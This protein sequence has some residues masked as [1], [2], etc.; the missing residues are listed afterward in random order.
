MRTHAFR[1]LAAAALAVAGCARRP[2]WCAIRGAGGARPR[3]P[4]DA[5][6]RAALRSATPRRTTSPRPVVSHR[7]GLAATRRGRCVW[8]PNAN[9]RHR[10]S[11]SKSSMPIARSVQQR[12]WNLIRDE[13]YVS[14][15]Q[16]TPV[17]T[18]GTAVDVTLVDRHGRELPMPTSFDD[19][20]SARTAAPRAF[21]R[22]RAECA[23]ARTR[24]DTA[25]VPRISIRVVALRSSRLGKTSAARRR[26]DEP[27]LI[28]RAAQIGRS[29][30][31]C[32][33]LPLLTLF[34]G[35]WGVPCELTPR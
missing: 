23:D 27:A 31:H 1:L 32:L 24:D 18:R 26:S 22:P 5:R 6:H 11:G 14:N 16:R 7:E 30:R 34:A 35:R 28:E 13:R 9:S 8:L 10:D 3:G 29:S 20:S 21:R 4:R 33:R 25:R 12:M 2:R 19:F 15:P 17:G